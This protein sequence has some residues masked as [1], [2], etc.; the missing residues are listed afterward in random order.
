MGIKFPVHMVATLPSTSQVKYSPRQWATGLAK[1]VGNWEVRWDP[2]TTR[3]VLQQT[4]R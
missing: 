4:A 3:Q 2:I 1:H